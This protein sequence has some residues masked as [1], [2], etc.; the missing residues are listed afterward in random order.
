MS[1]DVM[2]KE[3]RVLTKDEQETLLTLKSMGAGYHHWIATQ[4]PE[5]RERAIALTRLEEAVMWAV[6]GLTG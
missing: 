4:V 2:R 3:P 5:G 1:N 6:K